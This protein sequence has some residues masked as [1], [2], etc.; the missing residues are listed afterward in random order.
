MIL[1]N[2]VKNDLAKKGTLKAQKGP[3]YSL[4]G[5]NLKGRMKS[6]FSPSYK[7]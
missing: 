7:I 6:L 3:L 4:Y 1:P 2:L 5:Y